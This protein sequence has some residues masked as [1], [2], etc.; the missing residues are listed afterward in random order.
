MISKYRSMEKRQFRIGELA[1]TLDLEKYV[2]RFWEKE[3]ELPCHRSDGGQRFYTVDDIKTFSDIKEL[4]YARGFTI[5]GAKHQLTKTTTQT[6]TPA[7]T[8]K[9][10]Y[11]DCQDAALLHREIGGLYS[12]L[13][14]LERR[15]KNLEKNH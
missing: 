8:P 9:K 15:I 7:R 4:L 13:D 2:I 3:F 11:F 12:T 14:A 10:N 1:K 6:V 5:A